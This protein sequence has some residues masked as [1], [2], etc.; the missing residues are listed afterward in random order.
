MNPRLYPI[1]ISLPLFGALVSCDS[2]T[3]KSASDTATSSAVAPAPSISNGDSQ[4]APVKGDP[5]LATLA[6]FK[7]DVARLQ[8]WYQQEQQQLMKKVPT[9]EEMQA[10]QKSFLEKAR[11]IQTEG[12]PVDLQAAWKSFVG[13]T[14]E[15]QALMEKFP[16][17]DPSAPQLLQQA[18][19]AVKPQLDALQQQ[20]SGV[21]TKLLE[22]G[23][24]YGITELE[25]FA[26]KSPPAK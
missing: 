13:L 10:L 16:Q 22:L 12:L 25:M 21:G 18:M 19:T 26:P 24:K 6:G 17:P 20:A 9:R 2:K 5:A 14:G 3:Q 23:R 4:P 1:L 11:Q 15:I 8:S 7:Q